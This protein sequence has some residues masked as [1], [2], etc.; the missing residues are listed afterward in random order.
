MAVAVVRSWKIAEMVGIGFGV[1]V[2]LSMVAFPTVQLILNRLL[3]DLPWPSSLAPEWAV[4]VGL[5]RGSS[6]E[7]VAALLPGQGQSML[8]DSR[9]LAVTL[10][11]SAARSRLKINKSRFQR[12]NKL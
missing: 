3:V 8:V 10:P 6:A 9:Y 2:I 1:L 4:L 12:T 5:G 11:I 7:A